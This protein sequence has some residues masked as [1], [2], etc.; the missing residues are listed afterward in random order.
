MS[1][2]NLKFYLNGGNVIMIRL[3]EEL[4]EACNGGDNF[5]I[6]VVTC[7]DQEYCDCYERR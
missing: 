5:H 1:I 2:L 6:K 4:K 3:L 7:E